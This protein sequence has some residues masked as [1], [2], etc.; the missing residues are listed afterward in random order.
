MQPHLQHQK[1]QLIFE[2][3]GGGLDKDHYGNKGEEKELEDQ[4]RVLQEKCRIQMLF[5]RRVSPSSLS[6]LSPSLSSSLSSFETR[7]RASW[8]Q[9]KSFSC[10]SGTI[11]T[12]RR[13]RRRVSSCDQSTCISCISGACSY[14]YENRPLD[15]DDGIES[16]SSMSAGGGGGGGST[17][18]WS[19]DGF[20]HCDQQQHQEQDEDIMSTSTS[21]NLAMQSQD[22]QQKKQEEEQRQIQEEKLKMLRKNRAFSCYWDLP[23]TAN[24]I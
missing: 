12:R 3:G 8:D 17:P 13:Q 7:R 11:C 20:R 1:C 6:L 10:I 5:P 21:S 22:Q 2:R 19:L 9:S 24:E 14:C 15:R 18:S 16:S 23:K 4:L